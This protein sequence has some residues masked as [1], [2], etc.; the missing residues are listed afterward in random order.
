MPSAK[1]DFRLCGKFSGK[2]GQSAARWMKQLE[3]E[4]SDAGFDGINTI[5]P[6]T[7]IQAVDLLLVDEAANWAE[8]TP[9]VSALLSNPS[10][11]PE[12]VA[13]F[14]TLFIS[15]YPARQLDTPLL[16]VDSE[17]QDLKQGERESLVA[18]YQRTAA[19]LR[20]SGTKDR[21]PGVKLSLLESNM[22]DQIMRSFVRGLADEELKKD[23]MKQIVNPIRSLHQTY[24]I[25]EETRRAGIEFRKYLEDQN[26]QHELDFLRKVV[27]RNMT[28]QQVQASK[29]QYAREHMSPYQYHYGSPSAYAYPDAGGYSQSQHQPS[30]Q[31]LLPA[32]QQTG[33]GNKVQ[34]SDTYNQQNNNLQLYP[35]QRPAYNNNEPLPLPGSVPSQNVFISGKEVYDKSKGVICIVCGELGHIKTQCQGIPLTPKEQLVLKGLIYNQRSAELGLSQP[36]NQTALTNVPAVA[37]ITASKSVTVCS[38]PLVQPLTPVM[39]SLGEGS[40]PNKRAGPVP[41]EASRPKQVHFDDLVRPP[42]SPVMDQPTTI[43]G[44]PIAIP[45][46]RQDSGIFPNPA[47]RQ[48][49]FD[50]PLPPDPGT[51]PAKRT[52]EKKAKSKAPLNPLTGQ[53]IDKAAGLFEQPTSIRALLEKSKLEINIIDMCY[54][55]PAFQSETRRLLT[56][57]SRKP[58]KKEQAAALKPVTASLGELTTHTD[59]LNSFPAQEKAFRVPAII[60]FDDKEVTLPTIYTQ[61]DQGSDINVVSWSMAQFYRLVLNPVESVGFSGLHMKTADGKLSKLEYYVNLS[62]GVQGIWRDI[63]CFVAPKIAVSPVETADA[64][65]LLGLPWLYSVNAFISIRSSSIEIGDPALGEGS[66]LIQGPILVP[67]KEHNLLLYPQ[68]LID[69]LSRPTKQPALPPSVEEVSD[70]DADSESNSDAS[71]ISLED[72]EDP[73]PMPKQR[74]H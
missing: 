15:Q 28:P 11:G 43:Q 29:L 42:V 3:F 40:A 10:P 63:T 27:G 64:G 68:D 14:K 51:L 9:D 8:G 52:K 32:P 50:V 44:R 6:F 66:R 2:D 19:L 73:L 7:F 58:T 56:R 46:P 17:I 1:P 61:A 12:D 53:V 65:L 33:E 21:V 48:F 49:P 20:R 26:N 67:V 41:L 35:R 74:F 22:L 24:Q 60:R 5:P 25:V 16:T 13:E 36:L 69:R 38:L 71:S 18:Y 72:I 23:G 55:S 34:Q 4:L 31:Q 70:T 57:T 62:V 45:R 59:L 30:T 37:P 47:I 39:A 54:W